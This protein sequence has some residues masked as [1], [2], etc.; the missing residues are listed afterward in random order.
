MIPAE[1]IVAAGYLPPRPG[2]ALIAQELGIT[3][4]SVYK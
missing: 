4:A 2:R 1:T 3:V